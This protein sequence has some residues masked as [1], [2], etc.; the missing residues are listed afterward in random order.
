MANYIRISTE[1]LERDITE[2]KEE[3]TGVHKTVEELGD[4]MQALGATWEGPAWQ[5]F[6]SQVASDIEN[7]QVVCGKIAEFISHMEYAEKE[8]KNCENQV[9]DIIAGIR[10]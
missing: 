4:E 7:M 10:I 8:Y 2:I 3:L 6:Q 1:Q 5:A 9:H